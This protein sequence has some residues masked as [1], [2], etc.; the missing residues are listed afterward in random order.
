MTRFEFSDR[1][2]T[3]DDQRS[4]IN[5]RSLLLLLVV[6]GL[7]AATASALG[8]EA[9]P[10]LPGDVLHHVE[11]VSDPLFPTAFPVNA[12][13]YAVNVLGL[14]VVIVLGIRETLND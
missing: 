2:R 1:H 8:Q 4:T 14:L 10:G 13:A 6:F 9:V 7:L 11:A 5:A 12:L 3:I